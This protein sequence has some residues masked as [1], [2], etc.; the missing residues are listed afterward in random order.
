MY[1][2][3]KFKTYYILSGIILIILSILFIPLFRMETHQSSYYFNLIDSPRSKFNEEYNRIGI[4]ALV[5]AICDVIMM[6][7][8][9]SFGLLT[10]NTKRHRSTNLHRELILYSSYL[11]FISLFDF[12]IFTV[13][14]TVK[15]RH[16]YLAFITF[17]LAIFA[18]I[19]EI[20]SFKSKLKDNIKIK[21]NVI[22]EIII[23]IAFILILIYN[24]ISTSILST[25]LSLRI[26]DI[27]KNTILIGLVINISYCLYLKPFDIL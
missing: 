10:F 9:F 14:S 16:V 20:L 22:S 15:F 24:M 18:L 1:N 6:T 5:M 23:V 3:K 12:L 7:L 11:G 2:E 13:F 21:L 4:Q 19:L 27:F 17:I 8:L 25:R 26:L